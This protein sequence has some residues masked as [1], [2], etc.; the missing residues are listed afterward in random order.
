MRIRLCLFA[1]LLLLPWVFFDID[2]GDQSYH[3]LGSWLM[4]FHPKLPQGELPFWFEQVPIWFSYFVDS[5]WWHVIGPS[6]SLLYVRF[7]WILFQVLILLGLFSAFR[8]LFPGRDV[9]I[10]LL[11][12]LMAVNC[13]ADDFVLS[14]YVVPPAFG[15]LALAFVAVGI[16]ERGLLFTLGAGFFAALSVQSRLPAAVPL[17]AT[18]G[19]I[20]F[21]DGW[22]RRDARGALRLAAIFFAGFLLGTCFAVLCLFWNGQHEYYLDGLRSFWQSVSS[23]TNQRYSKGLVLQR[24]IGHYQKI[25]MGLVLFVPIFIGLR[26]LPARARAVLLGIAFLFVAFLSLAK[27]GVALSMV[28]GGSALLILLALWRERK[29]ISSWQLALALGAFSCLASFTLGTFLEGVQIFKFGLWL[30]VP[31]AVLSEE[32]YARRWLSGAVVVLF[33]VTRIIWPTFPYLERPI[34]RMSAPM[35]LASTAGLFSYPEKS[36][37]LKE[38]SEEAAALGATPGSTLF[39]YA[40]VPSLYPISG[41]YLLTRTVPLFHDPGMVEYPGARWPKHREKLEAMAKAGTLPAVVVR[42]K[43]VFP[44]LDLTPKNLV[45]HVWDYRPEMP[46]EL[47]AWSK[48]EG[49]EAETDSILRGAGYRPVWE[50]AYFVILAKP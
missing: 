9:V 21:V 17:A 39:V 34:F 10:P 24:A 2:L 3:S 26:I 12:G 20:F 23:A 27:Y 37:A 22:I 16:K 48:G 29:S 40:A 45:F 15:A 8:R 11:V 50:N 14:Y 33:F 18:F 28:I 31:Y 42:Q 46:T 43:N 44:R 6:A 7:G 4:A 13:A 30:L 41:I 19:L 1:V 32:G 25:S 49:L 38:V 5:L 36:A 47:F 35:A